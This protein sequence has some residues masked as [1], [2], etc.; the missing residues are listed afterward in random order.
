M[1]A[2]HCD[3]CRFRAERRSIARRVIKK[4]IRE[5]HIVASRCL[6][7]WITVSF[8]S[9]CGPMHAPYSIPRKGGIGVACCR[10][11]WGLVIDVAF[12]CKAAKLLQI[13]LRLAQ[14]PIYCCALSPSVCI[15]IIIKSSGILDESPKLQ[16]PSKPS[17]MSECF[18]VGLL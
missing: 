1:V 2:R 10:H 5:M 12:S 18:G 8:R 9:V 3:A 16:K 6:A 15:G 14:Q 4:S 11:L 13:H 17:I 7:S